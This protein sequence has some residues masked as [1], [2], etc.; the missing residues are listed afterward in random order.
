MSEQIVGALARI[1]VLLRAI[2]E[3]V[4]CKCHDGVRKTAPDRGRNAFEC[5]RCRALKSAS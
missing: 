5:P 1:E 2:L 3:S 4:E